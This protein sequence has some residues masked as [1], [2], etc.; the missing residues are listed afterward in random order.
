MKLC[1]EHDTTTN[2]TASRPT[3][4]ISPEDGWWRM[5]GGTA[6][7]GV[8]KAGGQSGGASVHLQLSFDNINVTRTIALFCGLFRWEQN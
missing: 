5:V 3:V 6:A 2:T 8:R 1:G 4:R 7:E